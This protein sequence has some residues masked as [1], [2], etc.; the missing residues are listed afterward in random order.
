MVADY[1]RHICEDYADVLTVVDIANITGL[2]KNSLQKLLYFV[3]IKFLT[4][5]PCY[6]VPKIYFLEFT[7]TKRF[8]DIRTSSERLTKLIEQHGLKQREVAEALEV[9]RQTVSLYTKGQALPDI[10]CLVKMTKL[11][12]VSADYLLGLTKTPTL[13]AD[14]RAVCDYVG[15]SELAV[16]YLH[17]IKD[18]ERYSRSELLSNMISNEH[19]DEFTA[20][21]QEF[22]SEDAENRIRPYAEMGMPEQYDTLTESEADMYARQLGKRLISPQDMAHFYR[23]LSLELLERILL[24]MSDDYVST[25]VGDLGLYADENYKP[26]KP[27]KV[28]TDEPDSLE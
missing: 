18:D 24:D 19:F 25:F 4:N 22:V 7:T 27:P 3:H 5:N 10:A 28:E 2:K 1:F 6:I 26:P 14:K 17:E 20:R 11:F 21:I 16:D 13:E 9:Q 15:L 23:K 12:N 8:R